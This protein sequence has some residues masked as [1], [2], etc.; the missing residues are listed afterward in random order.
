MT[1][2]PSLLGLPTAFGC[3]Y[4]TNVLF[5]VGPAAFC[6]PL[7]LPLACGKVVPGE[8]GVEVGARAELEV[9]RSRRGSYTE[10][11]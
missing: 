11:R 1:G 8:R 6:F 7:L 10:E 4:G 9:D 3:G 5:Q 2:S